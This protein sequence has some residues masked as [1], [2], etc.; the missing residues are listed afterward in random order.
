MAGIA[1]GSGAGLGLK[2]MAPAAEFLFATL[3][4]DEAL[5][6]FEWMQSVAEEDGK[7]L[8]INNSWGLPQWELLTVLRSAISL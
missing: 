6:A 4:V 7:R 5:D 2:G 1:G 3:M 8:V